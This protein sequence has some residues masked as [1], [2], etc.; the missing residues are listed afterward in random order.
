MLIVSPMAV[1]LRN[2]SLP[3]FPTEDPVDGAPERAGRQHHQ[4]RRKHKQLAEALLLVVAGIRT[5]AEQGG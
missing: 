3:M 5:D 1:K 4:C 2:A